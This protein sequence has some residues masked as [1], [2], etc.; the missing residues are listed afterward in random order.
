ML[1]V[2][3]TSALD[4]QKCELSDCQGSL[5]PGQWRRDACSN[6]A[7]ESDNLIYRDLNRVDFEK[8]LKVERVAKVCPSRSLVSRSLSSS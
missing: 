2:T 7:S 8:I 1:D 3:V 4:F 6:V 5:R